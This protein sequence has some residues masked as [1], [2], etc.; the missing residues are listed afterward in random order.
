MAIV[1]TVIQY[2]AGGSCEPRS[3]PGDLANP[4]AWV[5]GDPKQRR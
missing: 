3:V 5:V 4:G 2:A 1:S